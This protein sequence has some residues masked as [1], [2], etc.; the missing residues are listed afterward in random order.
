MNNFA[1]S[2]INFILIG[3]SMVIVVIG[4]LMMIG[5]SS[6]ENTFNVEIFSDMRI[7]VAPIVCLVGFLSVI[8]GI[9]YRPKNK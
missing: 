3:I 4:F 9:M 5:A 8:C 1:F 2:K 7:K 6:D